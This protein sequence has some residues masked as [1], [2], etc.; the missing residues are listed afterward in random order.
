MLHIYKLHGLPMAMVSD[1]DKIFTS[2][3]WQEWFHLAGVELRMS[4][5]Y[6]P[7]SNGQTK[8]VNQCMETF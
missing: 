2:Q 7:Q 3:L 5:A 8:R 4:S 6:H 1:R